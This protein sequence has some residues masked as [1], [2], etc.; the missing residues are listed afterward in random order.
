MKYIFFIFLLITSCSMPLKQ[1]KTS[2]IQEV[3]ESSIEYPE[4]IQ[5]MILYIQSKT[6]KTECFHSVLS[7]IIEDIIHTKK[8]DWQITKDIDNVLACHLYCFLGEVQQKKVKN[9]VEKIQFEHNLATHYTVTPNIHIVPMIQI[10]IKVILYDPLLKKILWT[11]DKMICYETQD[12]IE[13]IIHT[14]EFKHYIQQ[15]IDKVL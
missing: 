14:L 13:N 5:D 8:I 9:V 1:E 4:Y 15:I 11:H 12:S 2:A 7:D 6:P 10:P 3:R